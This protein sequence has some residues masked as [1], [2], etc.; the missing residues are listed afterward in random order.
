MY[1]I[2]AEKSDQMKLHQKLEAFCRSVLRRSVTYLIQA[3]TEYCAVIEL[4]VSGKR[5]VGK[6]T[7]ILYYVEVEGE[8]VAVCDSVE[9][10]LSTLGEISQIIRKKIQQLATIVAKM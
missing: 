3:H 4:Q 2:P 8:W 1:T 9:Y 10:H 7:I 5:A 6:K